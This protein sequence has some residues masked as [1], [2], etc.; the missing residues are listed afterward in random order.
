MD[1]SNKH[2]IPFR[3]QFD[4]MNQRKELNEQEET[5]Q[6]DWRIEVG[7]RKIENFVRK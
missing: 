6:A 5:N 1:E 4:I 7:E 3:S 2:K